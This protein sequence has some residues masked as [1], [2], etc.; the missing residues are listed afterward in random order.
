MSDRRRRLAKRSRPNWNSVPSQHAR[1]IAALLD[2]YQQ[3]KA[4][5]Y[6]PDPWS[7]GAALRA[8]RAASEARATAIE[9][10]NA[11]NWEQVMR[12]ARE[13]E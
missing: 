6:V 10:A 12:I 8:Q 3:I 11:R 1:L 7:S 5:T 4:G 9:A 2:T 13:S